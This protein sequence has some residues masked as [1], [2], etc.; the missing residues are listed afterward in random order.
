MMHVNCGGRHMENTTIEEKK[1]NQKF[2]FRQLIIMIASPG[3]SQG[4][5]EVENLEVQIVPLETSKE[6]VSDS[7]K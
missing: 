3:V 2:N 1:L 7:Q 5:E 6:K 4:L